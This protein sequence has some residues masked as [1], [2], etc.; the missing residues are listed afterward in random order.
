MSPRLVLVHS[1]LVGGE[2]WQPAAADLAGHGYEVDVPD[3]TG[4]VAAG[5]PYLAPAGPRAMM[6]LRA[7]SG[8]GCDCHDDRAACP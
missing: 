1:P 5:P 8:G 7:F 6:V 4:T 3:L 2:S